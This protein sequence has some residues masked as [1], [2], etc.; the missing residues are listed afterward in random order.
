MI[1]A[2][3]SRVTVP[4]PYKGNPLSELMKAYFRVTK[5]REI[6]FAVLCNIREPTINKI[7][8]G[9][10]IPLATTFSAILAHMKISDREKIN[11]I[12]DMDKYSNE[13]RDVWGI[14][15]KRIKHR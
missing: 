2:K 7:K 6:D 1:N 12:K 8:N 13:D 14:K 15:D 11:L 3:P 5:I 9:Q 4:P 10:S